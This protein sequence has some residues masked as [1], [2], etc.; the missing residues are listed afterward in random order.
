M[1]PQWA[2]PG[3]RGYFRFIHLDPE[4]HGLSKTSGVFIIWHG[5]VKPEWLYVG[6]AKNLASALHE[7]GNNRD[8]MNYENRGHLYVTWAFIKDE[9]QK[10]AVAYLS[11]VLKPLVSKAPSV[12]KSDWVPVITP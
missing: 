12:K 10:G 2:K 7:Q 4:E 5:G 11:D 9:F 8:L 1:D 6:A 3:E